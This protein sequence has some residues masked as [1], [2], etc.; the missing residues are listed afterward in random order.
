MTIP[1]V[2]LFKDRKKTWCQ[3]LCPRANLFTTLYKGRALGKP[4]PKWFTK[5]NLKWFVLGYFGVNMFVMIMST[6]MVARGRVEAMEQLR[7]FVALPIPWDL[8]Q[9]ISLSPPSWLVH[10]GYRFY[11][12]MLTTTIA[13]L[14]LGYVYTPRTWC[15]ICPINTISDASLKGMKKDKSNVAA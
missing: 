8:P 11:S 4:I 15:T 1:L 14:V 12:M 3:G 6:I 5:G 7:F 9:V 2:L 10:L 13:G